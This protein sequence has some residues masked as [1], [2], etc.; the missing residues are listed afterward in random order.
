MDYRNWS[1][2]YPNYSGEALDCSSMS[3]Y[4]GVGQ[5][6][7]WKDIDCGYYSYYAICE[8]LPSMRVSLTSTTSTTTTTTEPTTDMEEEQ[9]MLI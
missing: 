5:N 4:Q 9:I 6:G 2:G 7:M 1:P 3:L 8:R